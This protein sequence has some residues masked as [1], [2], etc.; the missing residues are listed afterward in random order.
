MSD[1][2][3]A[4]SLDKLV[5]TTGDS[6]H[7]TDK[8]PAAWSD[9]YPRRTPCVYKSG[10]PW[11]VRQGEQGIVRECRTVCRPDVEPVWVSTLVEITAYLKSVGVRYNCID[12]FAWANEGEDKPFCDFLLTVGVVAE[13]L[14]FDLAVST[15]AGVKK[16]LAATAGLPE[17][18]VAFIETTVNRSVR[19]PTLLSCDPVIHNV[20][21]HRKPF[22][23]LLGLPVAPLRTPYYEG[24]GAVYLE[25]GGEGPHDSGLAILTCA[26]V[27][28]P[29]PAFAENTGM[30]R[31]NNSQPKEFMAALGSGGYNRSVGKI[32]ADIDKH[33]RDIGTFSRQLGNTNLPPTRRTENEREVTMRREWIAQLNELHAEVTSH[34]STPELRTIGWA[35][36]SSPIRV[37]VQ[38]LGYTEDWGLIQVDPE[39]IDQATFVGNKLYFGTFLFLCCIPSLTRAFVHAR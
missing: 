21:K 2:N 16:I 38:P 1:G 27:I 33:T 19:G 39:M 6:K 24:T 34:R 15:A 10:N 31:T 14:A 18:E 32:R 23:A 30:T 9:F 25:L 8:Y 4:V 5:A 11:E 17:V 13:S 29:P 35:L 3:T 28:H 26:H 22:S 36:H 7:L 12:P 20:P 37:D